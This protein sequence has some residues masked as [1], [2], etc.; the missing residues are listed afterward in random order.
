[1]WVFCNDHVV[2]ENEA[3]ISIFDHGFLY[4]DGV[5]ETLRVYHGHIFLLDQHLARL[6]RSCE[7]IHL[8]LPIPRERWSLI[9][10]DLLHRNNLTDGLIRI[11]ISRGEGS[12]GPDSSLCSKPT[13]VVFPRPTPA[14]PSD[15]WDAGV[16]LAQVSVR[17]TPASALPTEIKSLNFLNNILAKQEALQAHAFD[18]IM[19]NHDGYLTECSASNIFFVQSGQLCTPSKASGILWG[20]TREVVLKLA[21]ELGIPREEG[22]YKTEV[23]RWAQ[24]CFL[25]NTGFEILPVREVDSYG[26]RAPCPGPITNQLRLAFQEFRQGYCQKLEGG[27]IALH[28]E[29]GDR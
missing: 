14:Y 26:F 24:E 3:R 11:T 15:L 4:G 19:L 12:L 9:L 18:G 17:R 7:L 16:R 10:E 23:L 1:M 5:F 28:S 2:K 6:Y 29:P 27:P 13:I 25:T 22:E 8:S 21:Q 20:I